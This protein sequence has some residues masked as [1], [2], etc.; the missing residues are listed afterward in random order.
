M[1]SVATKC[2]ACDGKGVVPAGNWTITNDPK[3]CTNCKGTGEV[4]K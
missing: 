3:T 2:P 1:S 4:K